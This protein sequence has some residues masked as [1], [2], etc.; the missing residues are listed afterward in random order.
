MPFNIKIKITLPKKLFADIKVRD[1]IARKQRDTTAP[2]LLRMF[3]DT[4]NGWETKVVFKDKQIINSRRIAM[5]VA[6]FGRGKGIYS[7][8]S[9]GAPEHPIPP[10]HGFLRFQT[11]YRSAT[12]PGQLISSMKRRFGKQISTLRTINHP[13]FQA[14]NFDKFIAEQYA[15]KFVEDMQDAINRVAKN[16]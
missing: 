12:R 6:P 1:T 9:L 10:K 7:L 14:R 3:K 2:D 4:T 11:G 5:Q 15:P 16:G 8:V 13:G